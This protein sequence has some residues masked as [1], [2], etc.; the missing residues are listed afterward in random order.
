MND[1]LTV[2][3]DIGFPVGML[4]RNQGSR[5]LSKLSCLYQILASSPIRKRTIILNNIIKVDL[6][7]K[8]AVH[9]ALMH[10]VMLSESAIL[11]II[12][13]RSLLNHIL[14]VANLWKVR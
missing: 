8:T 1:V 5:T 2:I 4:L 14:L 9:F 12:W 10:L 11:C 7:L 3:L 6:V 13:L